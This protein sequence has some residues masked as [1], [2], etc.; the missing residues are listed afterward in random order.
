MTLNSAEGFRTGA[1]VASV[2][3]AA[4]SDRLCPE[5][6]KLSYGDARAAVGLAGEVEPLLDQ[7]EWNPRIAGGY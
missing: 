2:R 3:V 5:P 7:G 4:K 6:E 1:L